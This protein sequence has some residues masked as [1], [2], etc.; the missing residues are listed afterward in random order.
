MSERELQCAWVTR[1]AQY[2]AY[3]DQQW[4]RPV[5]DGHELFAKLCLDGQQA[6]LS[7]ITILKRTE[8]YYRAYAG[9][10]PQLIAQFDE[11]DVDRLMQDPGIIR[12]RLKVQSIIKNAHAYLALQAEDIDV[13]QWLW[14]FVGGAPIVNGR[15]RRDDIPATSPE[16][17][18]MAKALKK[19]GFTFVG[20]TI[21]YA[22]MQA[23]G[24]VNDHLVSCPCH[25]LCQLPR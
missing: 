6:G 10:D 3:H 21:C 20:S 13:A 4:G 9:F 19:R 2:I 14:S 5:Y 16:S 17:D 25:R 15:Q 23:V 1:D 8:S 7:W 22:F 18:A 11:Q 12:N 24:M